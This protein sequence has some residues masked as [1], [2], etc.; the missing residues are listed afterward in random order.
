MIGNPSPASRSMLL[1]ALATV[2][3]YAAGLAGPFVL[4]DHVNLLPVW[5]W[6]AGQ[7]DFSTIFAN[8][9]GP[10]G[11]PLAMLSF[12]AN[13]AIG[14]QQAFG[15]KTVNLLLHLANAGLV[16]LL[17]RRL[18]GTIPGIAAGVAVALAAAWMLHPQHV[19][20][21][22]YV[23]QRMA[24]LGAMAQL[25]AVLV[26]VVARSDYA[27]NPR[28]SK[29]LLFA[30]FPALLLAGL[31]GKESAILAPLLCAVLELT[32]LATHPRPAAVKIFFACFLALPML[33]GLGLLML[34]P[35]RL[36]GAYEAREFDMATRVLTQPRVLLDYAQGW[37]WP[38]PGQVSLYRDGYPFSQGLFTPAS[39]AF[40]L[41]LWAT[42]AIAA[43]ITRRRNALFAAGVLW[44]LAAHTLES[45]VLALEPYFEHRNY[46][47]ALGLLLAAYGLLRPLLERVPQPTARLAVI[48]LLLGLGTITALR[49]YRWGDF[50]RL[51]ANEGPPAGEISRRL[52]ID[53][54][55]RG[56][57]RRDAAASNAALAV[58]A[59]GSRGDRAAA[60]LWQAILQCDRDGDIE[61]DAIA[62]L[63]DNP[64]PVLTHSHVSWLGLLAERARSGRCTGLAPLDV[65]AVMQLWQRSTEKPVTAANLARLEDLHQRLRPAT[66]EHSP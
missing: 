32:L 18:L 41:L 7:A 35:D 38:S 66:P 6:W 52:Q 50:D 48:A 39:A 9:S 54:A 10:F 20:A 64:P 36:L 47:A 56:F 45:S 33:L 3:A 14:G 58:L 26:Y 55:I 46:V 65:D 60:A 28:R 30:A 43:W 5:L 17:L 15:F 23:V 4:D 22:L 2:L 16:Y 25:A 34:F 12:A 42:A 31:F 51:L 63:R 29:L 24:L 44:F 11:R 19:S 8:P 13:A 40:A 37:F 59:T 53:R 62:R 27:R 61:I 1:A 21:V 57:E 49:A